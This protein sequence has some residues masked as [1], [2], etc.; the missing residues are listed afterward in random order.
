MGQEELR[1]WE[2]QN[3][4]K[5]TE[6]SNVTADKKYMYIVVSFWLVLSSL[7]RKSEIQSSHKENHCVFVGK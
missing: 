4:W 7:E 1:K 3:T 2:P 6:D 5:A